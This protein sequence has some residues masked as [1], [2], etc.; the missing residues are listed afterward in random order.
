M[1]DLYDLDQGD[2]KPSTDTK[3]REIIGRGNAADRYPILSRIT[4]V[5]GG[6]SYDCIECDSTG[7][8][9]AGRTHAAVINR[10]V[11]ADTLEANDKTPLFYNR[12]DSD[13]FFSEAI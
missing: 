6:H 9:I 1:T 2:S 10:A 4:A 5:N 13:F 3:V 11:T 12:Q 8:D 7:A